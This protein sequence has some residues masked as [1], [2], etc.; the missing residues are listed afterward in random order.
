MAK[1]KPKA[2][3]TSKARILR[4]ERFLNARLKM[5][6]NGPSFKTQGSNGLLV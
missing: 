5:P 3:T 4:L 1:E 6:K 2:M